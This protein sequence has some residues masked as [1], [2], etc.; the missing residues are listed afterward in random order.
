MTDEKI[1]LRK[2]E[3]GYLVNMYFRT[4]YPNCKKDVEIKGKSKK[5]KFDILLEKE[6]GERYGV[7]V[8]DWVRTLGVNQV[9]QLQKAC[10]DIP[11]EGGVLI[12]NAF[13]PSAISFGNRFGISCYNKYEILSKL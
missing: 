11:L 2:R 12:S 9:R 5:W 1:P 4:H 3:L 8:K 10:H 7:V 6:N 13:S